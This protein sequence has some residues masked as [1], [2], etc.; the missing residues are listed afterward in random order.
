VLSPRCDD[1]ATATVMEVVLSLMLK[2][3]QQTKVVVEDVGMFR[4]HV[5]K[6]DCRGAFW[7]S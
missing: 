7:D 3:L 1:H 6:D 2:V 4:K 5:H